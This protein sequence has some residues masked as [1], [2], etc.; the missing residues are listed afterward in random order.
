MTKNDYRTIHKFIKMTYKVIRNYM[1]IHIIHFIMNIILLNYMVIYIYFLNKYNN[2]SKK[3]ML[4]EDQNYYFQV[5]SNKIEERLR[6]TLVIIY[7]F[8]CLFLRLFICIGQYYNNNKGLCKNMRNKD[9][10]YNVYDENNINKINN[11]N[12]NKECCNFYE[13]II[14]V[15]NKK[16]YDYMNKNPKELKD[17]KRNEDIYISLNYIFLYILLFL[18]GVCNYHIKEFFFYFYCIL[19]ICEINTPLIIFMNLIKIINKYYKKNYLFKDYNSINNIKKNDLYIFFFYF[20]LLRYVKKFHIYG[21]FKVSQ[22]E[23][24]KVQNI[25][26]KNNNNKKKY[27]I[28]TFYKK[29]NKI[30]GLFCLFNYIKNNIIIYYYIYV[31]K[32]TI[33]LFLKKKQIN[34]FYEIIYSFFI[35]K[36]F[37]IYDTIRTSLKNV[38]IILRHKTVEEKNTDNYNKKKEHDI[39]K[40]DHNWVIKKNLC[41]E[42]NTYSNDSKEH[43]DEEEDKKKK[44]SHKEYY[45]NEIITKKEYEKIKKNFYKYKNYYEYFK[46]YKNDDTSNNMSVYENEII[47]NNNFYFLPKKKKKE[48][49]VIEQGENKLFFKNKMENEESNNIYEVQEEIKNSNTYIHSNSIHIN[50][51]STDTSLYCHSSSTERRNKSQFHDTN[52]DKNNKSFLS[53][54]KEES[55]QYKKKTNVIKKKKIKIYYK[56]YHDVE[57]INKKVTIKNNNNKNNNN[58]NNNNKNKN[59]NNNNNLMCLENNVKIFLSNFKSKME[60]YKFLKRIYKVVLLLNIYLIF[61]IKAIIIYMNI[62]YFIFKSTHSLFSFHKCFLI[63]L[64]CCYFCFFRLYLHEYKK[65]KK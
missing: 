19:I 10:I 26:K 40:Y 39:N 4:D 7:I 28:S 41:K 17:K 6:Y 51:I 29:E 42:I 57:D 46:K 22:S 53:C 12:K 55:I 25:K 38:L 60:I 15:G 23:K 58:K 9:N 14:Y 31:Y 48:F 27:I 2:D 43:E 59:N 8:F 16:K 64:Q 56:H 13:N 1:S 33:H 32:N 35:K 52:N 47:D 24:N 44:D 49:Q 65:L 5:E 36:A 62:Y 63:L 18:I 21:K 50:K 20:V 37:I 61:F 11:E 54:E 34:K 45:N 30:G 3:N